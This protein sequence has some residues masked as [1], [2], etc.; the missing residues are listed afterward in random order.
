MSTEAPNPLILR[1]DALI[2]RLLVAGFIQ[3]PGD[4]WMLLFLDPFDNPGTMVFIPLGTPSSTNEADFEDC[5]KEAEDA[6]TL[7]EGQRLSLLYGE[8]PVYADAYRHPRSK[9]VTVMHLYCPGPDSHGW[10]NHASIMMVDDLG[11]PVYCPAV[12]PFADPGPFSSIP[13]A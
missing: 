3:V 2:C 4:G 7:V 10:Y 8:S 5:L 11:T 9:A 6:C 12:T 13:K 1:R